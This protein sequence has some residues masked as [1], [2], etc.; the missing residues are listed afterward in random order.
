MAG[1]EFYG[2]LRLPEGTRARALE[3]L[4]QVADDVQRRCQGILR[5]D[6]YASRGAEE[7]VT[8][9]AFDRDEAAGTFLDETGRSFDQLATLA[10]GDVIFLGEAPALAARALHAF[11]PR[12][13]DFAFGR[14]TGPQRRPAPGI[15][16]Y[17]LFEIHDG[18]GDPIRRIGRELV[19]IV[20]ARDPGTT[21]Y[22]WFFSRNDRQCIAMDS[23]ADAP[24]MFAHMRNAHDTHEQLFRHA[25]MKVEFLGELPA[26]AQAA[27]AKYDPYVL[28]R[29]KCAAAS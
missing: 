21:R 12:T 3:L 9:M 11:A 4:A 20:N 26:E 13:F 6:V 10:Q 2:K 14:E 16:V 22:D 29:V 24:S 27:V 5:C 17:T 15:E 23:Y 25:T 19:S 7:C 28:G 8:M 1:F 18:G